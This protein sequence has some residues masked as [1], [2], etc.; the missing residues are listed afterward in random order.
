MLASMEASSTRRLWKYRN[1][2]CCCNQLRNQVDKVWKPPAQGVYKLNVD[3]AT[4][5]ACG[6][7]GI[8]AVVRNWKGEVLLSMAK[9][10][11]A[12]PTLEIAEA[13]AIMRGLTV[14]K[15][16]G[17]SKIILEGDA[18][19]LMRELCYNE[20]LLSCY[21]QLLKDARKVMILFAS[22]SINVVRRNANKLAHSLAQLAK[23]LVGTHIWMEHAPIPCFAL[24]SHDCNS[25][26]L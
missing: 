13:M 19:I 12:S 8:G 16:A 22:C 4:F 10:I 24:L 1:S 9:K 25:V 7:I 14:A 21:G 11:A 3:G 26:S 23:S 15:E 20:E 18:Q 2:H 17:F 5:A 6:S